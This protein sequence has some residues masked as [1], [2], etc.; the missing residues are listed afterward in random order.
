MSGSA[1]QLEPTPGVYE[2]CNQGVAEINENRREGQC[3]PCPHAAGKILPD[4]RCSREA[5]LQD[6]RLV[7]HNNL[8]VRSSA[9]HISHR[10]TDNM[11][12]DISRRAAMQATLASLAVIA[13]QQSA[14]AISAT[15]M[16][17]KTKAELG[18]VLVEAPKVDGKTLSAD[19]V[20]DG[21]LSFGLAGADATQHASSAQPC[22]QG[23]ILPLWT[24][25]PF[26]VKWFCVHAGQPTHINACMQ[27]DQGRTH[28]W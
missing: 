17:G 4:A 3:D 10:Q 15:T 19:L 24:W 7:K 20:L 8:G 2:A 22:Y 28:G 13:P 1:A 26:L 18:M 6:A 23:I 25:L 14:L 27:V 11:R 12:F 16:T 9:N 5:S 21:G